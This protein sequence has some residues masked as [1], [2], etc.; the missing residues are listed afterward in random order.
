MRR[1]VRGNVVKDL[2]EDPPLSLLQT[3]LGDLDD[4]RQPAAP[5][6]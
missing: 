5:R 3:R 6:Q 4:P 2:A 1:L